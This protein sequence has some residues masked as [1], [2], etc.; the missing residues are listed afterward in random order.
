MAI[1]YVCWSKVCIPR[2]VSRVDIVVACHDREMPLRHDETRGVGE[3]LQL[4]RLR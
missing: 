4:P 2:L 1:V 3:R